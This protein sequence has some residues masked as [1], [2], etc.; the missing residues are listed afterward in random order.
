MIYTYK[1]SKHLHLSKIYPILKEYGRWIAKNDKTAS[2]LGKFN[3]TCMTQDQEQWSILILAKTETV[4]NLQDL[5][6]KS[7]Q[8]TDV[9]FGHRSNSP[10]GHVV[11]NTSK[12]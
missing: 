2:Y 8:C 1:P 5:S 7:E 3:V 9:A 10:P 11:H 6:E 12:H 4:T